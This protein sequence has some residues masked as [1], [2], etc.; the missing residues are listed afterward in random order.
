MPEKMLVDLVILHY[1]LE[2]RFLVAVE[3]PCKQLWASCSRCLF[4]RVSCSFFLILH[5]M[6]LAQGQFLFSRVQLLCRTCAYL[7]EVL[8]Q[9]CCF[10][11]FLLIC[12]CPH[13]SSPHRAFS[14]LYVLCKW[15]RRNVYAIWFSC[16]SLTSILHGTTLMLKLLK[17][18]SMFMLKG[19]IPTISL[20]TVGS[21]HDVI[22][23]GEWSSCHLM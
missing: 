21:I 22:T 3:F 15:S 11:G 5:I 10:P 13:K 16:C 14:F 20:Y 12:N 8:S 18:F 17:N 2:H 23:G 7:K 6:L 1:K 4:R 19:N 9:S